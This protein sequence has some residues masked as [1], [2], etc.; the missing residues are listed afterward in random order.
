MSNLTSI[1]SEPINP[2][3]KK[4]H[5]PV[6]IGSGTLVLENLL[7]PMGLNIQTIQLSGGAITIQRPSLKV[8]L[9]SPADIEA[10]VSA[11]DLQNFLQTKMPFKLSDMTLE[12]RD[13]RVWVKGAVKMLVTLQASVECEIVILNKTQ[14][15]AEL[16]QVQVQ[17]VGAQS[18]FQNAL[19][20]INPVFDLSD[21]PV[22]GE[23]T[24]VLCE[25]NRIKVFG[26]VVS[27][28]SN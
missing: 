18:L 26:K 5:R 3:S 20:S 7:L 14:L 11:S 6:H 2:D 4:V 22:S 21:L 10:E 12:I 25:K 8:D 17:G 16:R 27:T 9:D 24:E 13:Q 15:V 1:D 23:I 28:K 19:D